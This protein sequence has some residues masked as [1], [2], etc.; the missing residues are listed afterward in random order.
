MLSF[1]LFAGLLLAPPPT[2]SAVVVD[3]AT[4][5]PLA[6]VSV[7][8]GSASPAA[9]TDTRGRFSIAVAPSATLE[10]ALLGYARLRLPVPAQPTSADT[11]RLLPQAYALADVQVR[12]PR[13]LTF[14]SVSERAHEFGHDL[15]PGQALA[16]LVARPAT[17]PAEQ[18]CVLK[19]VRL[20]LRDK[21][22]EG[23]VRLRLVAIQPVADGHARPGSNDLLPVPLILSLEQL[24]AAP[25]KQVVIDFSSYNLLVPAAGLC[26]VAECLTTDPVDVFFKF[27]WDEKKKRPSIG[28]SHNPGGPAERLVYWHDFPS[29]T[30]RQGVGP[31]TWYRV[32]PQG[33]WQ[34]KTPV[35]GTVRADITV[36]AY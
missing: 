16:M 31:Q 2:Y 5:Q 12:P 22:Q 28:L 24:Q 32:R 18:P 23:R 7:R 36:L 35:T 25:R 6:G 10:L 30:A 19:S 26:V 9:T 27:Q 15:F 3:A 34:D 4:N 11:L 21:P 8:T 13:E 14:S 20:Y 29:F 33:E 1:L 17:V